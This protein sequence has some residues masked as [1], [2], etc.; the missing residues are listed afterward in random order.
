[1]D[2]EIFQPQNDF[3]PV[4]PYLQSACCWASAV[5]DPQN[6]TDAATITVAFLSHFQFCRLNPDCL[7]DG[8]RLMESAVAQ[9]VR[10]SPEKCPPLPW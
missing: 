3:Y 4:V 1:M 7:A 6:R 10:G 9:G 2:G 8:N 5:L